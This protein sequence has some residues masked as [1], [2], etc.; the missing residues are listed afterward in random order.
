M[1]CAG[2]WHAMRGRGPW[3]GTLLARLLCS[4]KMT[5]EGGGGTTERPAIHIRCKPPFI[6]FTLE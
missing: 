3:R 4:A 6:Q 2:D 5:A 1:E